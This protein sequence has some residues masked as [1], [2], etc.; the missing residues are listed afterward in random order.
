MSN[1]LSAA[2]LRLVM[3]MTTDLQ[4]LL[5]GLKS[6]D[7]LHASTLQWTYCHL[8]LLIGSHA[9]HTITVSEFQAEVKKVGAST[10]SI[11]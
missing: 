11:M 8:L 7:D 10:P 4:A 6:A 9:G 2:G 1:G 3:L 5:P